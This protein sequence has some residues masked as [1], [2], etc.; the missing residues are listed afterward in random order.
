[1]PSDPGYEKHIAKRLCRDWVATGFASE[2]RC[3]TRPI[4]FSA[5]TCLLLVARPDFASDL[6]SIRC[7]DRRSGHLAVAGRES[8]VNR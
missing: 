7:D 2:S 8:E 4:S 5:A 3:E 6:S 1:M